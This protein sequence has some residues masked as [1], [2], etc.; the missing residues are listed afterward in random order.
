MTTLLPDSL[1]VLLRA[2]SVED[3]SIW[4]SAEEDLRWDAPFDK[5]ADLLDS[6]PEPCFDACVLALETVELEFPLIREFLAREDS[7]AGVADLEALPLYCEELSGRLLISLT[8]LFAA[9]LPYQRIPDITVRGRLWLASKLYQ[10]F[11]PHLEHALD[12]AFQFCF[13]AIRLAPTDVDALLTLVALETFVSE[14]AEPFGWALPRAFSLAVSDE[15]LSFAYY[16]A[17]WRRGFC[18]DALAC[19]AQVLPGTSFFEDAQSEA[20]E[21]ALLLHASN[22]EL[23]I[24]DYSDPAQVFNFINGGTVSTYAVDPDFRQPALQVLQEVEALFLG[25]GLELPQ[26]PSTSEDSD[27]AQ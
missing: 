12:L 11:F 8:P 13:E 22:P 6:D 26:P 10:G 15:Q 21:V 5:A 4:Q 3:L 23:V 2:D 14:S 24:P 1:R 17:A 19:Y 18:A 27:T 16:R 7:V 9:N 25:S 20:D